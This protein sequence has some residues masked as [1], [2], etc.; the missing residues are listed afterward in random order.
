ML[1]DF[2]HER[3]DQPGHHATM[4][5]APGHGMQPCKVPYCLFTRE[6]PAPVSGN[7]E[8]VVAP[9]SFRLVVLQPRCLSAGEVDEEARSVVGI[10]LIAR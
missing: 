3:L 6:D 7:S 10:Y 8:I 5:E 4:D 9:Q 1:E 2:R